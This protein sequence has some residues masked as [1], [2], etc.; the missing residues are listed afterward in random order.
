MGLVAMVG[1]VV[2]GFCDSGR[3]CGSVRSCVP[4]GSCV[5]VAMVGH[6]VMV[7]FV[8]LLGLVAML[9]PVGLVALAGLVGLVALAG[10]I[11]LVSLMGLVAFGFCDSGGS[12]GSV[13]SCCQT[14]LKWDSTIPVLSGNLA[15]AGTFLKPNDKICPA[16]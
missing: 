8:A 9:G 6:V 5:L 14:S 11:G 15:P 2:I 7:G 3:S 4:D 16:D 13:G 1:H 12:F 10:L